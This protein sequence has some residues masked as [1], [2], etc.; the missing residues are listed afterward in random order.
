VEGQ[1][2]ALYSVHEALG[3]RLIEFGGWIMPVQYSSI[4]EEH[5]AVRTA[6]GLFDLSHMGE[7]DL[8]GPTAFKDVQ[9]LVANDVSR[10]TPGQSLYTPMCTATGKIVD[11]LLVYR[12]ADDHF[13]LCVNASN[14][15]KDRDWVK[16]HLSPETKF[17]DESDQTALV[18]LQ[19]P[20]APALLDKHFPGTAQLKPFHFVELAFEG[21]RVIVARTGYTGEDGYEIFVPNAQAAALWK[22]LLTNDVKPIGLGARDTLRLEA[23]LLLYGNDIDETT[24]PLEAGIGW[25]VKLEKGEFVGR[26]PLVAEK[27]RGIQRKLVGFRMTGRGIARHGHDVVSGGKVVGAVT[28]GSMSP[29]LKENIGLAYVAADLAAPGTELAIRIRE[30]DVPAVVVPTPF[31]KRK[32]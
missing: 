31:Y 13:M 3:A 28:S 27:A 10:L 4:L 2:T 24:S 15:P 25:T 8:R 9:Q 30:K 5:Q 12:L 20:D 26:D 32:K 19:G 11:D 21:K 23:R 1:K 17:I 22:K 29:T 14:I 6:A 16:K 7:F 18:A